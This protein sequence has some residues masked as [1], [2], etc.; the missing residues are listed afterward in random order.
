[1]ILIL[2]DK[3]QV[4]PCVNLPFHLF[5]LETTLSISSDLNRL[6][7]RQ[8]SILLCA[9]HTEFSCVQ[10]PRHPGQS[11]STGEQKIK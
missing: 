7:S 8:P 9:G 2:K 1:M 4:F 11:Y 5:L 10:T 3:L 6:S